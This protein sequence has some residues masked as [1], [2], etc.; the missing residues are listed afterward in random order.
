MLPFHGQ[1]SPINFGEVEHEPNA[2]GWIF[3][4][5]YM[6]SGAGH[7]L[8]CCILDKANHQRHY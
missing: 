7:Y 8:L 5:S 1:H 3:Q 4:K 6:V 2:A